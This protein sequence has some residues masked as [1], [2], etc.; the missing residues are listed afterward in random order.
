M[1]L[2]KHMFAAGRQEKVLGGVTERDSHLRFFA[3]C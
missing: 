3:Y 2:P 1:S